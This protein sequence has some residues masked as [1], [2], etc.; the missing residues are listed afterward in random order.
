MATK[1]GEKKKKRKSLDFV[2]WDP[3]QRRGA[4]DT[5]WS[6]AEAELVAALEAGTLELTARAP[7]ALSV[8][9]KDAKLFAEGDESD[10]RPVGLELLP[11]IP[12]WIKPSK[13][14]DPSTDR[15]RDRA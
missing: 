13:T 11:L 1:K 10:P 14:G 8:L 15:S 9:A 2:A 3:V 6:Y 12:D 5:G 4:L 7:Y